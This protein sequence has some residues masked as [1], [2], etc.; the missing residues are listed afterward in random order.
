MLYLTPEKREQQ[1]GECKW[2]RFVE[3]NLILKMGLVDKRKVSIEGVIEGREGV[4]QICA[5]SNTR[6]E[7]TAKGEFKWH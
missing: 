5:G 6:K 2:H 4:V 3:G 7:R 1:R